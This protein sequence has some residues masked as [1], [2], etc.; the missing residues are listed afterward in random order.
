MGQCSELTLLSRH[1]TALL[2]GAGDKRHAGV[3]QICKNTPSWVF[4]ALE[5]WADAL[6][7]H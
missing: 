5:N 1:R 3:S 2:L 4:L 7:S 6:L